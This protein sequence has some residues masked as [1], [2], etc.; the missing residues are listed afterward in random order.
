MTG[1]TGPVPPQPTPARSVPEIRA[2][3]A[4]HEPTDAATFDDELRRAVAADAT[5]INLDPVIDRWWRIAVVRSIDLSAAEQDQIRRARRGDFSGL[6]EQAPDGT[7]Q[8]IG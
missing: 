3:L 6:L 4:R 1:H 8:R 2:A 5:C 7:F